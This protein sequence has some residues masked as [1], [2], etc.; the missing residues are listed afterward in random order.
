MASCCSTYES[1]RF[2]SSRF[3]ASKINET[4]HM[5][6][7]YAL[8]TPSELTIC[9]KCP[10]PVLRLLPSSNLSSEEVA[11]VLSRFHRSV[12]LHFESY[13][14]ISIN[15][16]ESTEIDLNLECISLSIGNN[17]A[18]A[19]MDLCSSSWNPLPLKTC[20]FEQLKFFVHTTHVD[21]LFVWF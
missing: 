14:A 13:T 2:M 18:A 8:N 9:H 12:H 19:G 10:I 1:M 6:P 21:S 11:A 3:V 17:V 5:L 15:P 16:S 4:V 7:K 20:W